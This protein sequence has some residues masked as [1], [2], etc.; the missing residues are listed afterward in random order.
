MEGNKDRKELFTGNIVFGGLP[1][2]QWEKITRAGEKQVA[3]PRTVIFRQGNSG[4]TLYIIQSGKVRVFREDSDG[5]E[6]DLAVLGVGDSFGEM[7]LLTGEIRAASVEAVEETHLLLLSKEQFD[8]ILKDFPD[9]SLAMVKQMSRRLLKADKIIEKETQHK[10]QA[11]RMSWFDFLLVIGVSVILALVFNKSNPNGIPLF[12]KSPDRKA[13]S[14]ISAAQAMEE[15]EKG[16]TIIVDAGPEGFYQKK[17]IQGAVSVPLPFFDI[18]YG[19]TFGGE[20]KA[21]KVIVYGGTISKLY[22]WESAD[23]LLVRGHKDVKVLKGGAEAWEKAGYPV[24]KWEEK[25]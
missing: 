13:I 25:K 24:E 23:K 22:D 7:G 10:Y 2:E 5:L 15:M 3:A 14:E 12:S 20:E 17:H 6:T 1:K 9:I 18:L 19:V 11:S 16:G 4:D 8:R 21:K